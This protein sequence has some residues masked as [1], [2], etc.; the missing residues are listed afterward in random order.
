M[1]G[2]FKGYAAVFG[3]VDRSGDIIER[4]AFR[5]TLKDGGA[6]RPVFVNHDWQSIPIGVARLAEDR[7]GLRVEGQ[8]DLESPEGRRAYKLIQPSAGFDSGLLSSMSI[9]YVATDSYYDAQG[10]RHIIELDLVEISVVAAPAN[11][12]ARIEAVKGAELIEC[13]RLLAAYA[14]ELRY[15][16]IDAACQRVSDLLDGME[17]RGW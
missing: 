15:R 1:A 3:N 12:L 6:E 4:G 7:T 2:T 13:K 8:I 14:Q 5:K 10:V 9:G 17:R 16:K 11:A